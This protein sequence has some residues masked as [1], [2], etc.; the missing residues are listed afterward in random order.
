VDIGMNVGVDLG[1]YRNECRCEFWW[2]GMNVGVD[3]GGY[4]NECR[5]GFGWI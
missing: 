1:G 2:I 5:C 3:L 4:R